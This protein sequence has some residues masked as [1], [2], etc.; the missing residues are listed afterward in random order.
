MRIWH[1]LESYESSDAKDML[2]IKGEIKNEFISG[3]IIKKN[4]EQTRET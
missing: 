1:N 4:T 2:S 3:Y